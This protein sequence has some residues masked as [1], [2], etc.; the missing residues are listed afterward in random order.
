MTTSVLYRAKL[1]ISSYSRNVCGHYEA[2][3]TGEVNLVFEDVRVECVGENNFKFSMRDLRHDRSIWLFW[4]SSVQERTG[5]T[6]PTHIATYLQTTVEVVVR[7]ILPHL[8]AQQLTN[9]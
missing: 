4:L 9:S 2:G 5:G 6:T 1:H 8:A 3:D 7:E